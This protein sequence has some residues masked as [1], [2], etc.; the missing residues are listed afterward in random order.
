METANFSET[1]L[2][3]DLKFSR[4]KNVRTTY[5]FDEVSF[6]GQVHFLTL[7]KGHLHLKIKSIFLR[8]CLANQS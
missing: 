5:C 7:A 4:Y 6:Q 8:K 1:S 3:C 2:A